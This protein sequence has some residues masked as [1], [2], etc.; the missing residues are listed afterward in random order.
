MDRWLFSQQFDVNLT[1]VRRDSQETVRLLSGQAAEMKGSGSRRDYFGSFPPAWSQ[2][3]I[4]IQKVQPGLS[5]G[6]KG[7]FKYEFKL[8]P[9]EV[10]DDPPLDCDKDLIALCNSPHLE[11]K[12]NSFDITLYK[13]F[14]NQ[15][16]AMVFLQGLNGS[17]VFVRRPCLGNLL[18]LYQAIHASWY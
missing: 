10:A 12:V 18:C 7:A 3:T 16:E 6:V 17:K 13:L 1:L 9:V 2:D 4:D 15:N 8:A 14:E 5:L 11:F